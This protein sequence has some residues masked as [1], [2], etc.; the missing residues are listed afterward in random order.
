M[1]D[2]VLWG[3]FG[4]GLRQREEKVL[5][6]EEFGEDLMGFDFILYFR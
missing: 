3:F 6:L 2:F 1:A 5:N 4:M